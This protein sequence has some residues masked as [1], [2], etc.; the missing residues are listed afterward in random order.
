MSKIAQSLTQGHADKAC[1]QIADAI[2]DELLRQDP[3]AIADIRVSLSKDFLFVSG[4]A[5]AQIPSGIESIALRAFGQSGR[6]GT[7]QVFENV[8]IVSGDGPREA[9]CVVNGYATSETQSF[10]PP[11]LEYA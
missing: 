10:L 2:V 9:T 4:V 1:D 8:E 5:S 7:V 3:N 6:S 11:A